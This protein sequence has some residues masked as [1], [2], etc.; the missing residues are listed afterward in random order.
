M[1]SVCSKLNIKSAIQNEMWENIVSWMLGNYE[2]WSPPPRRKN[3]SLKHLKLPE[4]QV[5]TNLFFVQL[6]HSKSTGIRTPLPHLKKF[7]FLIQD[8]LIF[9]QTQSYTRL[10]SKVFS[11]KRLYP[12]SPVEV[13]KSQI[14]GL[15][16]IL[17]PKKSW[18]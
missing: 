16:K 7:T 11:L 17:S 5:K 3:I 6:K 15:I 10:E 12:S 4:N 8:F 13:S 9:G 1:Y 18:V 14:V 2:C